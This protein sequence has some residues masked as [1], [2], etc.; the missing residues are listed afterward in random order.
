MLRLC[1]SDELGP[2]PDLSHVSCM[3]QLQDLT[4]SW[5]CNSGN[6]AIQRVA[7]LSSLTALHLFAP[8][9]GLSALTNLRSLTLDYVWWYLPTGHSALGRISRLEIMLGHKFELI[10]GFTMLT[11]LRT[12]S[13]DVRGNDR[14]GPFASLAKLSQLQRLQIVGCSRLLD[15]DVCHLALLTAPTCLRYSGHRQA[16]ELEATTLN[17]LSTHTCLRDLQME[18]ISEADERYHQPVRDSDAQLK[19]M[20]HSSQTLHFKIVATHHTSL[21]VFLRVWSTQMN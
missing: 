20:L 1:K 15:R 2:P 17:Q 7:C 8:E 12:L 21:V 3:T 18:F 4:L 10:S 19:A 6:W 13:L 14:P 11:A 9:D 16:C 5:L